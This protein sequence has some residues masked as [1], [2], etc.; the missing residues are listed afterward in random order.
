MG[1]L[2]PTDPRVTA[3]TAAIERDL[4]FDGFIR[5]Y[6]THKVDDGMP[7]GEGVFL[8]CSFW[9]VDNLA[10]QGRMDEAHATYERLLHLVND[11]GLLSEEYDP[12]TKR[13][14][15]NFPQAFSH[16]ALVHTGL[17]LMRHEE[18]IARATGHPTGDGTGKRRDTG[19]DSDAD[20]DSGAL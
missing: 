2:P 9:L 17:N 4:T 18:S 5:R 16:V 1:F 8:A 10:L 6:R 3:T 12:Q 11:V 15:G 13:F 20:A 14:T 19:S 7:P